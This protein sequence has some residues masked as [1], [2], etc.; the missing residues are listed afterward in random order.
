MIYIDSETLI[1]NVEV[2]TASVHFYVQ[3][4]SDFDTEYTV[5]PFQVEQLN[6]GGAMDTKTGVFTAPVSGIY[7]FGFSCL[8]HAKSWYLDIFLQLNGNNIG[9]ATSNTEQYGGKAY[10]T[11]SMH[12]SLRLKKGDR[13]NLYKHRGALRDSES[14]YTHFSGWLVEEDMTLFPVAK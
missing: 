9:V 2:K 5:I 12:S 7:H 10:L 14:R 4:Q 3:R 1:G 6:V 13:I 11:I 8:M